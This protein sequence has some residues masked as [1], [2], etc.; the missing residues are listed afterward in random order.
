MT[1]AKTYAY[2]KNMDNLTTIT[3]YLLVVK[4]NLPKLI[5]GK[6]PNR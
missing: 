5:H 4:N 3:F 1:W 6:T 2:L